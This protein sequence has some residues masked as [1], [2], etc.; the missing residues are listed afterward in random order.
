MKY[1]M[2]VTL[3]LATPGTAQTQAL[4]PAFDAAA[5][6]QG[7]PITNPYLALT[8]GYYH[9]FSGASVDDAGKPTQER[10][11]QTLVGAGPMIMGLQSTVINDK[12][13]VNGVMIEDTR[14]YFAQDRAG[15]VWYLGEDASSIS[16]DATGHVSGIDSHSSWRAGVNGALPGYAMMAKPTKGAFYEQEHAP[17]DGALDLGRILA[18]DLTVTGPTGTYKAV[19]QVFESSS[20]EPAL[21]EIKYYAPGIGMIREDEGVDAGFGNPA[22]VFALISTKP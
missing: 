22:G 9:A 8:P 2:L 4:L 19:V 15:N 10:D 18:T 13:W 14:D 7:A 21:R 11:V 6:D 16:Y 17:A 3:L 12:A 1:P 20:V 5:F